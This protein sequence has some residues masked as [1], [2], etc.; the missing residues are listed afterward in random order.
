MFP[1]EIYFIRYNLNYIRKDRGAVVHHGQRLT[2]GAGGV[3]RV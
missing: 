3:V 2:L 1:V